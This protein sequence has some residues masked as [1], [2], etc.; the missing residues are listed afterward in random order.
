MCVNDLNP[1]NSY[2][3]YFWFIF[4]TAMSTLWIDV[5]NILDQVQ[6]LI[7]YIPAYEVTL[8]EKFNSP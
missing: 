2:E 4:P 7:K 3:I 5:D 6:P 1:W 8:S